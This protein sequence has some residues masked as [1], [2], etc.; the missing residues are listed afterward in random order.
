VKYPAHDA[1]LVAGFLV[2]ALDPTCERIT[3]A[4]S[5]RRQKAEVGDIEILYSPKDE[6][7]TRPVEGDM[8]ATQS[9]RAVD[10]FIDE[11]VKANVLARRKNALGREMFGE[12]N[13]LM[14]HVPSGIPV[15]LFATDGKC[16]FNAL[17]CRTG[18]AVLNQEIAQ[19]AID[20]GW[21]WNV[22]GPGF[23][24]K[25]SMGNT[26]VRVVNSEE[27]VFAFVGLPYNKPEDR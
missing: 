27:E 24:R 15:D 7:I 5:L 6:T 20:R 11:L 25:D 23:S 22:Y 3:I 1:R 12:K 10:G 13:K 9:M 18:P 17:V 14:V 8:F 4:G 21:H 19:R 26:E 2:E 16:W